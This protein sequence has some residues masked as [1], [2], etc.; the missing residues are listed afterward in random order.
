MKTVGRI[1]FEIS[2]PYGPVL[3]KFQSEKPINILGAA[4]LRF[5]GMSKPGKIETRQITYVTD[6]SDKLFLSRQACEQLDI[7]SKSFP[8]VG[9]IHHTYN[10]KEPIDDLP[11]PT[12]PENADTGSPSTTASCGCP[13]RKLPPSLP[14]KLPFAPIPPNR[15]KLH[16]FLVTYYRDSTF[17][18]C[19]HQP[20]PMIIWPT[21]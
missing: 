3:K 13:K 21:N 7:I 1:G 16:Q 14:T 10:L 8:T 5:S 15:E 11:Q 4:I 2:A 19:E 20:L 12:G 6:N 9:E 17:N 18:T